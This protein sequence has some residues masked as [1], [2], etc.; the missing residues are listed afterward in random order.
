MYFALGAE[1][2]F[3]PNEAKVL[4]IRKP[5][6]DGSSASMKLFLQPP[7]PKPARVGTHRV[8]PT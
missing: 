5:V 1:W 7:V 8:K 2:L 3:D 4:E 6:L